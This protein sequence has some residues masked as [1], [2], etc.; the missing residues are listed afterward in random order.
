VQLQEEPTYDLADAKQS[1]QRAIE[2]DRDSPTAAI[3]L[4]HF[5]DN[6]EDDP[7]AAVKAYA[8][9][10][11]AARHLLIDGLIGQAKAYRQLGKKEDVLRCLVEILQLAQFD[12]GARRSKAGEPG[13]DILVQ[14]SP[15]HAFVV[16]LKG[17]YAEEVQELL[18]ELVGD[19]PAES[20]ATPDR[21][22]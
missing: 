2:L 20:G 4:G 21:R 11:A 7:Q 19:Q 6:V 5:L 8:E 22:R 14:S 9:G 13:A 10:V 1:L 3:E 15:G 16:Q 17:P 12:S 18:G